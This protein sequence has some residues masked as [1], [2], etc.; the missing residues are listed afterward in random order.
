M[1]IEYFKIK[2][3]GN[4]DN[5]RVEP[6]DVSALVGEGGIGLAALTA[7]ELFV[8]YGAE[9]CGAKV[10]PYL[11]SA[12]GP[13]AGG[14]AVVSDGGRRYVVAREYF[15]GE[16]R[17]LVKDADTDI[18]IK[19][20]GSAGEFFFSRTAEEFINGA[21]GAPAD[22]S[23]IL[24]TTQIHIDSTRKIKAN[25]ILALREKLDSLGKKQMRLGAESMAARGVNPSERLEKA[26][27]VQKEL[28]EC[29]ARVRELDG[30]GGKPAVMKKRGLIIALCVGGGALLLGVLW[31]LF[32]SSIKMDKAK[33]FFLS[34][35]LIGAGLTVLL[36]VLFFKLTEKL[37]MKNASVSGDALA[38]RREELSEKLDILLEG[39]DFE[40]LERQAKQSDAVSAARSSAEIERDLEQVNREMEEARRLL[41]EKLAE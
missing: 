33:S 6:G 10:Q 19:V 30:G 34:L 25:E 23:E 9:E 3:F 15:K 29:D 41:N 28:L 37:V 31:F 13:V 11:D 17:L 18:E 12:K 5:V 16:E 1:V 38:A 21:K 22:M 2:S 20:P 27:R 35:G 26:R 40:E 7:F 4:A 39:S 24:K 14:Y 8:F 32:M 36:W